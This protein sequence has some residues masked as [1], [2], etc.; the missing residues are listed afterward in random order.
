MITKFE[1]LKRRYFFAKEAK[2]DVF[3][4]L[5]M[6]VLLIDDTVNFQGSLL[7]NIQWLERVVGYLLYVYIIKLVIRVWA[8]F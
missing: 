5:E 8:F 2:A 6:Y 7:M 1:R 3:F 4:F